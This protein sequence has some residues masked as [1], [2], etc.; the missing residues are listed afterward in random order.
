MFHCSRTGDPREYH[1]KG[2]RRERYQILC[3]IFQVS[4]QWNSDPKAHF[5]A[6][7]ALAFSSILDSSESLLPSM[8][9]FAS[10]NVWKIVPSFPVFQYWEVS[11]D[12]HPLQ[13]LHYHHHQSVGYFHA[14]NGA[15]W[16]FLALHGISLQS[17]VL[18]GISWGSWR[19][20]IHQTT[21]KNFMEFLTTFK[22]K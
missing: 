16:H 18:H 15:L 14:F 11:K 17:V 10:R 7:S 13:Y 20:I 6:S 3:F 5:R 21:Y 9:T 8:I 12:S 2:W 19:F 1:R 4:T 22:P